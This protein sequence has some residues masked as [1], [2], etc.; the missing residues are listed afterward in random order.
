MPSPDP[1]PSPLSQWLEAAWSRQA[2]VRAVEVEGA[3]VRY[4]DWGLPDGLGADA[5]GLLFV[6]GFLA[7]AHWWD[8]IAPH[9]ADHHH[10]IAP[11]FSGMGDS[12]RRG[13]YSRRQYAREILAALADA[14]MSGATIVAHS[15]G[16]ISS[17]LAAQLAPEIVRRVIVLDAFVFRPHP[18]ALP[19]RVETEKRYA[20]REEAL[21]RYRL[22]PAGRWPV[23]E[24]MAYLALHS[25]REEDGMWGWKF[26]PGIFASIDKEQLR[27]EL[28][29]LAVPVDFVRAAHSEAVDDTAMAAFVANMP[30]CG[31]P[32]TVPLSHHHLMIEQPVALV[33]ALGGLLAHPR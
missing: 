4:R 1:A 23:P 5:P 16:A 3:T 32:V 28:R 15:F 11:D 18:L 31:R 14:G 26:D 24:I 20:T 8:H 21:A 25:L 12:D 10:V 19:A 30:F 6:H 17:L 7:H 29:G 13:G 33:S 27:D 2:D 9:F 22:R